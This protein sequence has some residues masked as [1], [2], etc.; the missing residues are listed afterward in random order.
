M[1]D[2]F[3]PAPAL[4]APVFLPLGTRPLSPTLHAFLRFPH[5]LPGP[6]NDFRAECPPH[7]QLKTAPNLTDDFPPLISLAP[8]SDQ[9]VYKRKGAGVSNQH[10]TGLW[11]DARVLALACCAPRREEAEERGRKPE[12]ILAAR[13]GGQ[14]NA[15][16]W[17]DCPI[18]ERGP[19]ASPPRTNR[20]RPR[21]KSDVRPE[22]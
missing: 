19:A 17:R 3:S 5:P 21:G 6:A 22:Q 1:A 18:G 15:A 12:P 13:A 16:P 8:P 4:K 10:D 2:D 11:I 9:L 14:S 7:G 20:A